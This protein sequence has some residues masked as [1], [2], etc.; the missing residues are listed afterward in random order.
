MNGQMYA[1]NT[2]FAIQVEEDHSVD[3]LIGSGI[4]PPIS[5]VSSLRYEG[6]TK[7]GLWTKELT[8]DLTASARFQPG[9]VY[10]VCT[11]VENDEIIIFG[12]AGPV[13]T[14]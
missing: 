12:V 1:E 5:W 4:E 9:P 8:W 10:F 2:I 6:A 14:E 7:P 11:H 3:D 13:E